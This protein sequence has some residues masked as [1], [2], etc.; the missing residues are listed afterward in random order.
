MKFE[1]TND[2]IQCIIPIVDLEAMGV[3]GIQDLQNPAVADELMHYIMDNAEKAGIDTKQFEGKILS[4]NVEISNDKKNIRFTI[5]SSELNENMMI[6]SLMQH[7][8]S[9]IHGDE[10][11]DFED[12]DDE[13]ETLQPIEPSS[14]ETTTICCEFKNLSDVFLA[15]NAIAGVNENVEL[16]KFKD[17]YYMLITTDTNT[18]NK[19]RFHLSDFCSTTTNTTKM[20][21]INEHGKSLGKHHVTELASLA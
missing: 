4:V 18:A 1:N 9:H 21:L 2:S 16:S 19:L 10:D 15:C 7:I 8:L 5:T 6:N 20:A 13:V 3:Q 14:V 17:M 11:E 12:D